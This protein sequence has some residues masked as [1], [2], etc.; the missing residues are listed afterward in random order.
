MCDVRK[1]NIKIDYNR[2]KNHCDVLKVIGTD[3]FVL[4]ISRDNQK[5]ILY[6]MIAEI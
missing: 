5:L 4:P 3:K 6:L 2:L 1:M